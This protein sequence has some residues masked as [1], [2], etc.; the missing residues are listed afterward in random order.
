MHDQKKKGKK[1]VADIEDLGR[2]SFYDNFEEKSDTFS[3]PKGI[4]TLDDLKQ[5]GKDTDMCPYFL[6]RKFLI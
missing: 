5:L 4:Y 1:A 6:A 3:F 2:C